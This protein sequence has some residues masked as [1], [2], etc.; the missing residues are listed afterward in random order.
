MQWLWSTPPPSD[1]VVRPP[2]IGCVHPPP[3]RHRL[4]TPSSLRNNSTKGHRKNGQRRTIEH[5]HSPLAAQPAAA[6]SS[7]SAPELAVELESRQVLSFV[8][9]PLELEQS[10][11]ALG[12]ESRVQPSPASELTLLGSATAGDPNHCSFP[13]T[14]E[15]PPRV[16]GEDPSPPGVPADND[17]GPISPVEVDVWVLFQPRTFVGAAPPQPDE[18]SHP[19]S[20]KSWI[21]VEPE[22]MQFPARVAGEQPMPPEATEDPSSPA[23]LAAEVTMG[24][25]MSQPG[26]SEGAAELQSEPTT[27]A[28]ELQSE[29]ITGATELQPEPTAGA[30]ES[31]MGAAELQPESSMGAMEF[32]PGATMGAAL[33]QSGSTEGVSL[34]QPGSTAGA[35]KLQP[36]ASAGAVMSRTGTPAG[37]A[38]AQPGFIVGAALSRTGTP[39]GAMKL[40]PG[41]T[42]GA[43][44]FH[45]GGTEGVASKPGD[46]EA[47]GVSLSFL[48][49]TAVVHCP[50]PPEAVGVSLLRLGFLPLS[51]SVGRPP[52]HSHSHSSSSHCPLRSWWLINAGQP[53]D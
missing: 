7:L 31:T 48:P 1:H 30:A 21:V 28:A 49:G 26:I 50:P 15:P 12:E 23:E 4:A 14:T 13:V 2:G 43:A 20:S 45:S 3:P 11:L 9:R 47:F 46:A 5:M 41:V 16:A 29:P 51:L 38:S 53:P 40:Q 36:G 32:Q 6:V 39:A 8:S 25:T 17:K 34:A 22:F 35:A 37:A 42:A 52:S 33:A 44:T 10:C 24:A 27:G 19:G 18:P